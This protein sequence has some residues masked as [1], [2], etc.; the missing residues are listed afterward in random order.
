MSCKCERKYIGSTVGMLVN[1]ISFLRAKIVRCQYY[2]AQGKIEMHA[3]NE[4]LERITSIETRYLSF[5]EYSDRDFDHCDATIE[6]FWAMDRLRIYY[7]PD[8]YIL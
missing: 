6:F 2:E 1:H 8:V 3:V 4:S 5:D 7:A